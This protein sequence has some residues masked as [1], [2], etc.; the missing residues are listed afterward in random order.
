L[1]GVIKQISNIPSGR[2]SF[3][4][5][6][7]FVLFLIS[8]RS[9]LPLGLILVLVSGQEVKSDDFDVVVLLDGCDFCGLAVDFGD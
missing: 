8:L 9:L 3:I 2:H 5:S 6:R 4:R 1:D 7:L